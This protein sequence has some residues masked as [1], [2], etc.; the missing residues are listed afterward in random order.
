MPPRDAEGARRF[1]WRDAAGQLI[2]P[3]RQRP[4]N[5]HA[6]RLLGCAG[7]ATDGPGSLRKSAHFRCDTLHSVAPLQRMH[8]ET[9]PSQRLEMR[10]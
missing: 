7:P 8:A 5:V 10:A 3:I 6:D 9:H 1:A 4:M 2:T